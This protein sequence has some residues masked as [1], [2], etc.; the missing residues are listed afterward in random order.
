MV[1]SVKQ[2]QDL[3]DVARAVGALWVESL[4]RAQQLTDAQAEVLTQFV[5]AID[6][7]F[8][9][10]GTPDDVLQSCADSL[11]E[12]TKQNTW[13]WLANKRHIVNIGG[14]LYCLALEDDQLEFLLEKCED[15]GHNSAVA[16]IER[17]L[18]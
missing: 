5:A 9:F 11:S 10:V 18:K 1:A 7:D 3:T 2:Q 14:D 13:R 8:C 4:Y 12:N 15:L 16:L 17:F 6:E